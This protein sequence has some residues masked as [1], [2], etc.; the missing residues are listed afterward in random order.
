MTEKKE[1]KK[2]FSTAAKVVIGLALVLVAIGVG[3]AHEVLK[4]ENF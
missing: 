3:I 4:E 2:E 1:E